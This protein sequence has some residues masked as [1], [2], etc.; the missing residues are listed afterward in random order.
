MTQRCINWPCA[1]DNG[2]EGACSTSP[3]LRTKEERDEYVPHPSAR[4]CAELCADQLFEAN[5]NP[6]SMTLDRAS[7]SQ[8]L[9]YAIDCA[10][11][12]AGVTWK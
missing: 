3:E 7:L 9:A 12:A 11:K 8:A 2:H 4:T 5:G 1:K 6:R 10:V